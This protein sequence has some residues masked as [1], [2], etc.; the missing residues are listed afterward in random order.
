MDKLVEDELAKGYSK[1]GAAGGIGI[2]IS[3]LKVWENKHPK[4]RAAI[5]RGLARGL[6]HFEKLMLANISGVKIEG[7]N[8]YKS[9]SNLI[10]YALASR[11]RDE[12]SIQDKVEIT[13]SET[14]LLAYG[15]EK[16]DKAKMAKAAKKK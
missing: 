6:R 4:F 13:A 7:F 3:T 1:T 15:I 8:P 2:G 16:K 9:D 11:F 14:L 12:Y 5:E 10:K